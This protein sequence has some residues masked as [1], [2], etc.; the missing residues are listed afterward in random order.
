MEV[1]RYGD[2][3]AN[4]LITVASS[5]YEKVKNLECLGSLLTNQNTIQE[6]VKYRLK[7]GNSCYCSF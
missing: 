6:E 4:E 7:A 5:S 1:R 3:M 2:M